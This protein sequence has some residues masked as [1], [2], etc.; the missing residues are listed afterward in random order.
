MA[1]RH[2]LLIKGLTK[3]LTGFKKQEGNM[4]GTWRHMMGTCSDMK[5]YEGNIAGNMKETRTEHQRNM[6][7]HE[8]HMKGT[9]MEHEGNM[10]GT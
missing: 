1:P 5:G 9:S 8:G 3:N 4:E 7:G 10:K 2:F 6:E